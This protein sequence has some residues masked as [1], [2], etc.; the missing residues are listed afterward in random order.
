MACGLALF[1]GMLIPV[2][3]ATADENDDGALEQMG[4]YPESE[5]AEEAA[6][7]PVELL[8]ALDRDLGITGAQYLA[9]SEA[10]LQAVD[11]VESLE[12]AG[13]RV[14]GSR[15]AGTTLVVNVDT[16]E[17]ATIVESVG[18]VAAFGAPKHFDLGDL[19][20]RLTTDIY[21]GGGWYWEDSTF[22]YQCSI[23]L[24][25]YAT[26]TGAQQFTTAGHCLDG[27]DQIVG[28]AR[29]V[30]QAS[31]GGAGTLGPEIGLPVAGSQ[32]FDA[33]YD[34]GRVAATEAG[35]VAKPSVLTWGGG[36]GAPLSS[37][38][39]QVT[40][41]T[42]GIIG[43]TLCKS[44][45][46]T[47]WRCGPIVDIDY[48]AD[49]GGPIINSIVAQVCNLPGDS[50]GAG[51]MGTA[52]V[53]ISSWTTLSDN[54]GCVPDPGQEGPYAGLFPMNSP[55]ESVSSA[56]GSDW[57]L[58]V[59]VPKPVITSPSGTGI[60]PSAASG[61]LANASALSTVAM[62]IDGSTTAFA[63]GVDASTGSWSIPLTGVA[64]GLHTFS[65]VA[66]YGN[67]STSVAAT[68]SFAKG[69]NV[70]RVTGVDRYGTG[71]LVANEAGYVAPVPV[72]FLTTGQNYPDALS[73]GP[74]A[75]H[76]GGPLM[77][78]QPWGISTQVRDAIIAF[79]PVKVIVLGAENSVS[80][81]AFD[82]IEAAVPTAEVIRMTGIDR[83]ETSRIIARTSFIDDGSGGSDHLFVS[84]G[85]N[86]PD[87]LSAG[88]AAAT[89]DA[90]VLMVPGAA[91]SLPAE[92]M[93]LIADLGV[94][95]IYVTGAENSVS[96]GIYNQLAALAGPI[97][98]LTGTNRYGTSA[99]INSTFFLPTEPRV[100]LATG[101]AYPDAL[102]GSSLAGKLGAPL[103]ITHP[104]CILPDAF[105]D[106]VRLKVTEVTILGGT[107]RVSNAVYNLQR[108]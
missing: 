52:A 24:N 33:G 84:N 22:G 44:G 15:I 87:A 81:A 70:E 63:T 9:G 10:A 71:L 107:D 59:S 67:W 83:Y 43:A 69:V 91:S 4:A 36:A 34:V 42:A 62:F 96:A 2:G 32:Q 46:R 26:D 98:R 7:L 18:G 30:N 53:G 49:V 21:G 14:L 78:V 94:D 66:S 85:A 65:V 82:Q 19:Q 105:N 64:D 3:S 102:V 106:L 25:G 58:A 76:L 13:I 17:D 5:F 99:A 37:A 47:G 68:G 60:N 16:T 50:G 55:Y 104:S 23:G 20:P 80:A 8:E 54:F 40:G 73:A 89:L 1:G 100:I 45:S 57:E 75:V 27:I 61:T 35:I 39:L 28:K 29:V 11:V 95:N 77:L 92:T 41:R 108:C 90:P 103:Y 93:Q 72:L 38:A 51:L 56:Y 88:G 101:E 31:P 86:F 12:A 79:Q 48:L 97:S 6:D 74:A